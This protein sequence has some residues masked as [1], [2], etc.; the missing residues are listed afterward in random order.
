MP[1]IKIC[2]IFVYSSESSRIRYQVVVPAIFIALSNLKEMDKFDPLYTILVILCLLTIWVESIIVQ[3]L[4]VIAILSDSII[5][6]VH[7]SNP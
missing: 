2:N 4:F 7:D 1:R 3:I 6:M 5:N